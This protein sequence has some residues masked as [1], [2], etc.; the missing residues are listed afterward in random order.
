MGERPPENFYVWYFHSI[1]ERLCHCMVFVLRIVSYVVATVFVCRCVYATAW[2]SSF[3]FLLW[4]CRTVL[5]LNIHPPGVCHCVYMYAMCGV[6]FFV[7]LAT[8]SYGY[9][10]SVVFVPSCD[11]VVCFRFVYCHCVV[12]SLRVWF[13]ASNFRTVWLLLTVLLSF[14]RNNESTWIAKLLWV[15]VL[16]ESPWIVE[17]PGQE[18]IPE[19]PP[20]TKQKTVCF[21]CLHSTVGAIVGVFKKQCE[22]PWTDGKLCINELPWIIELLS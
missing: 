8:E 11:W 17:Y 20:R 18:N 12:P 21:Y 3:I 10:L 22:L 4:L 16:N 6:S 19:Q 9:E 14:Y 2:Y 1:L 15:R 7:F 13:V 5:P